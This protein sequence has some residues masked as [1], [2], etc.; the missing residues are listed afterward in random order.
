MEA[1]PTLGVG[2]RGHRPLGARSRALWLWALAST[3]TLAWYYVR[4][5]VA[6]DWTLERFLDEGWGMF[7]KDQYLTGPDGVK[8]RSWGER[9][10]SVMDVLYPTAA[11]AGLL[12]L[13]WWMP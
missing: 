13:L 1:G 4:E 12:P 3:C 7:L 2:S 5:K 8:E 6:N 9:Y 10:D 11:W